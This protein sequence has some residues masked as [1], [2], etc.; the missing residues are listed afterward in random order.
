MLRVKK[1]T[2][3]VDK[4]IGDGKANGHTKSSSGMKIDLKVP[5]LLAAILGFAAMLNRNFLFETFNSFAIMVRGYEYDWTNDCVVMRD[6]QS[7]DQFL[8]RPRS[9]CRFCQSVDRID[10]IPSNEMTPDLFTEKYAWSGRP[11]VIENA[12]GD[13]S[14]LEVIDFDYLRKLYLDLNRYC[15]SENVNLIQNMTEHFLSKVLF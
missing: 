11:V 8:C 14:A 13:W 9:D 3:L 10:V 1:T 2:Q 12:A 6:P 7:G 4:E 15:A 5:L